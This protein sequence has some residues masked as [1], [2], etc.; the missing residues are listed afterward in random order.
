[1]GL[2]CGLPGRVGLLTMLCY[3]VGP[4]DGLCG[5]QVVFGRVL[6]LARLCNCTVLQAGSTIAPSQV[7]S[8]D[9][10]SNQR[11][12]RAMLQNWVGP[13]AGLHN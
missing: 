12:P 4:L 7:G 8:Q 6:L 13:Q 10:L 3:Q 11:V 5:A 1:M 2:L 9:L